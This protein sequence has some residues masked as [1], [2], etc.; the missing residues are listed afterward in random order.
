MRATPLLFLFAFAGCHAQELPPPTAPVPPPGA[1]PGPGPGPGKARVVLETEGENALVLDERARVLCTTPCVL[2]FT[3]GA[4]PLVFVSASD[5]SRTSDVDIDVGPEPK[6]VRHRIGERYE[7]GPL[8]S[9]G[10][11]VLVLGAVTAAGGVAAWMTDATEHAPL[12][13]GAGAG[14]AGLSLPFLLFDRPSEQPGS[15]TERTLRN[16]GRGQE[17]FHLD[18]ASMR[19]VTAS[20]VKPNFCARILSGALAP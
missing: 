12:I 4:H 18:Q 8:R 5:R 7:G 20:T 10:F 11:A 19:S 1:E 13:T 17:G 2:D 15:T 6:I 9:L 3:Y 16:D 14:L